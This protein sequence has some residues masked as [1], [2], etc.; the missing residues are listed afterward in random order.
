MKDNR[1]YGRNVKED[2]RFFLFDKNT[3]L[4][5]SIE[6]IGRTYPHPGY[7]MER[8]NSDYF[9]LEYVVSGKGHLLI[10]GN[11]FV[12]Q[13]GDVYCIEPGYDH[14]YYADRSDPYE[15]MW[16]NFFSD[17]FRDVMKA[18]GIHE[19]F[20]FPDSGCMSFF[21]NILQIS[22]NT[23]DSDQACFPVCAQIGQILCAWAEQVNGS[24]VVSDTARQIRE[25]L[26]D[27]IYSHISIE[28][29]ASKLY[30]SKTQVSRAFYKAYGVTPYGYLLEKKIA[31]AKRFLAGTSMSVGEISSRLSFL[32]A[33]YFSRIFKKKTGL[34]PKEFRIENAKPVRT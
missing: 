24:A 30:I 26:D 33:H 14:V 31:L 9:V 15:K 8:K 10:N 1:D 19:R 16:I 5:I 6:N 3:S 22:K 21:Q 27:A 23:F 13:A 34:S 20:V 2:F 17:H 12:V 32:D 7:R 29:I 4:P 18:Y 11:H 28:E 25:C